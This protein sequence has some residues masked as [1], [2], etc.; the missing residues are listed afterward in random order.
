MLKRTGAVLQR[1]APA[2]FA[3][4]VETW[5]CEVLPEIFCRTFF[6]VLHCEKK[7]IPLQDF[8]Q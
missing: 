2:L 8:Y 1:T 7:Y 3:T 4:A 5:H 6:G